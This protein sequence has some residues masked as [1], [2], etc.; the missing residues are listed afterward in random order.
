MP[1]KGQ[2]HQAHY[3]Q[4]LKPTAHKHYQH[5][6]ITGYQDNRK[7]EQKLETK[8]QSSAQQEPITN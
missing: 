6:Q 8:K 3:T 2:D 5:A 4:A 1:P 7:P